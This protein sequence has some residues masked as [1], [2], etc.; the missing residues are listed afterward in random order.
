MRIDTNHAKLQQLTKY[1]QKLRE[2]P[3]DGS[4]ENPCNLP[5][6]AADPVGPEM[7]VDTMAGFKPFTTLVATK[8]SLLASKTFNP[9][10]HHAS[11]KVP[12]LTFKKYAVYYIPGP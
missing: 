2:N 5:A 7:D 3:Q 6:I 11:A 9:L 8:R 1:I 12:I 10:Q 4:V